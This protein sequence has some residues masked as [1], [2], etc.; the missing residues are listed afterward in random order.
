MRTRQSTGGITER[1]TS[2]GVSYHVRFRAAGKRQSVHAGYACDGC[3]RKDAERLLAYELERVAR[4]EWASPARNEPVREIPGFREAASDH[5]AAR[6]IEGGRNGCGLRL[7]SVA[8]L[9]WRFAHL[10]REFGDRPLDQIDVA[11]V[12]RYRRR[13]VREGKLSSR[14]INMTLAALATVLE[15]ALEQGV[16][17]GRN[18]AT[19]KRRRLPVERPRR[20]YIDRAEQVEALLD[21]AGEL[22]RKRPAASWRRAALA[23]LVLA[24][25]RIGELLDLR[26]CDV[27]LA[28]GRL[29]V[30]VGKTAAA[31]RSVELLP[32]LRDELAALAAERRSEDHDAYVFGTRTGGRQQPTNLRQRVLTPAVELA[33]AQLLQGGYEPLPIGLTPHSLRRTFASLLYA[34]GESPAHVMAQ[35]GHASPNLALAIYARS[36]NRRVGEAE[37][38]AALVGQPYR[39][40]IGQPTHPTAVPTFA[41]AAETGG[42]RL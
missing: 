41:A 17:T 21:A 27:Y 1:Q 2:R 5:L 11:A 6:K 22:D 16:I 14:S 19:G 35:M 12:D 23:T 20:T 34:L 37:R 4:G 10:L 26:W 28:S 38:L 29:T 32:L 18:A 31:S 9:E 30:R 13:L 42:N 33:N 3:T 15:E 8:D 25:L 24:G 39:G 40:T 36:M 7:A